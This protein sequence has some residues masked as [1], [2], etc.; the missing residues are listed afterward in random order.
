MALTVETGSG[1]A[2]ANAFISEA[3]ADTYHEARGNTDWTDNNTGDK[4]AAIRRATAILSGYSWQ[5]LRTNRR[6]QALAWPRIS[7]YDAEG[8]AIASDEI[9]QEVKDA[10]AEMAMRELVAPGSLQPDVTLSDSLKREK[11][12]QIEV[13]Y[14]GGNSSASGFV[15]ILTVI[16]PLIDQFLLKPTNGGGTTWLMRV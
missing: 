4:E 5:G 11:I 2:D 10:C 8:W 9:P 1:L 3:D 12:G 6:D 14:L 7:V 13:E 16:A 15:P